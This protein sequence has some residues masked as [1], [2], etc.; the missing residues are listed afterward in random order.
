MNMGN[1]SMKGKIDCIYGISAL[2]EYLNK[3]VWLSTSIG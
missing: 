1:K 3:K 2:S